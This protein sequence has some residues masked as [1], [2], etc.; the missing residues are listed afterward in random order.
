MSEAK[1]AEPLEDKDNGAVPVS[2]IAPFA[3]FVP[4]DLVHSDVET[5][6]S[7]V[8]SYLEHPSKADADMKRLGKGPYLPILERA[9]QQHL[10][11]AR[12][13]LDR[14]SFYFDNMKLAE[15]QVHELKEA[16]D[17][18]T[19]PLKF[20][21]QAKL[22]LPSWVTTLDVSHVQSEFAAL[23][24]RCEQ[25]TLRFMLIQKQEQLKVAQQHLNSAE[26]VLLAIGMTLID[27]QIRI[28]HIKD[29]LRF[30]P[31]DLDEDPP[32]LR[33]AQAKSFS[34]LY[35]YFIESR[36]E[37]FLRISE[38]EKKK[39]IFQDKKGLK[40]SNPPQNPQPPSN[41]HFD[42]FKV[43]QPPRKDNV[44]G[45]SA[46]K[47]KK[48]KKGAN[49]DHK[50]GKGVTNKGSQSLKASKSGKGGG[51]AGG[52]NVQTPKHSQKNGTGKGRQSNR[53]KGA[54]PENPKGMD[55]TPSRKRWKKP[56]GSGKGRK[57][58]EANAGRR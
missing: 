3:K 26:E 12:R 16:T 38:K 49:K 57:P 52:V 37:N 13:T 29:L 46:G 54:P 53:L 19:C 27:R 48:G 36:F 30:E 56:A 55:M 11:E 23:K 22:Q 44:V 35:S 20:R 5:M 39:T 10:P 47:S 2:L 15:K 32:Q 51:G 4:V 41:S 1:G 58:A 21:Y 34:L 7:R 28:W 9:I 40:D 45:D 50:K 24:N 18:G 14:Y 17:E 43:P 31:S 8:R 33:F 42:D 25:E 6:V